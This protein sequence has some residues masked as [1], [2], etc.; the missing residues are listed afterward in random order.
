MSDLVERYVNEVVKHLPIEERE[1]IKKELTSNILEQIVDEYDEDEVKEVLNSFGH[2]RVLA[3]KYRPQ[4]RY[5]IGPDLIDS[6]FNALKVVLFAIVVFSIA[7]AII[8]VL[9]D[10][11]TNPF[12]ILGIFIG[13]IHNSTSLFWDV[14][15]SAFF[16]ITIGFAIYENYGSSKVISEW[17]AN[18]LPKLAEQEEVMKI[19]NKKKVISRVETIVEMIIEIVFFALFAFTILGNFA[20]G[21]W[22]GSSEFVV[23]SDFINI[24]LFRSFMGLF[25]LSF[26]LSCV[27]N[28]LKIIYG[29]WNTKL[30]VINLIYQ[31][32]ACGIG[33]TFLLSNNI[34]NPT[35]LP[36]I[37]NHTE[38][39]Q[40]Q[41]V[42]GIAHGQFVIIGII[43][44]VA[45]FEVGASIYKCYF[46]NDTAES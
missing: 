23:I 45:V 42:D 7:I 31:V 40:T 18:E 37:I 34:I 38:F 32:I 16:W 6:Y 10:F 33:A 4:S 21:A 22:F 43:I 36:T 3:S 11:F 14:T 25:V 35:I 41:I 30:V 20:W 26:V 13:F 2:P 39:N 5:L 12:N 8:R 15:T 9:G 44:V 29:K 28:L 24:G 17:N 19:E 46:T 1:E 27:V